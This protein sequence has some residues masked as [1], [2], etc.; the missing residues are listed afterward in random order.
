MNKMNPALFDAVETA[1]YDAFVDKFKP[2]KTTDDCYT[3]EPVYRAVLD[4]VGSRVDLTGKNIVRPFYPNGNYE[5]VD[6]GDNDVVIDN[7]PFSILAKIVRF[8]VSRN[9]PFF[10]FAPHLTMANSVKDICTVIVSHTDIVYENGA[11]VYTGFVSNM[12]GDIA[13]MTAPDLY[14][15]VEKCFEN[16]K[17]LPKYQY[18]ANVLTT[19]HVER[20]IRAGI[21]LEIRRDQ[22]M[23]ISKL[24]SQIPAKKAIF[25]GG[26]LISDSVAAELAAKQEAAK[27]EAA[28]QEVIEWAL[29]E[30]ERLVIEQLR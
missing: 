30:Q 4:W 12:F 10:L 9:I 22:C 13:F 14:R 29:S 21:G 28:K 17:P 20:I 27:Q 26:Y 7:P 5:T 16:P 18:P 6:Y 2:K 19:R 23:Y 3:P 1:E 25:G 8:Y 11:R 15:M 24:R